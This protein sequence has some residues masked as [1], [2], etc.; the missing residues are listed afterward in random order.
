EPRVVAMLDWELATLGH[1]LADLAYNCMTYHLPAGHAVAAGF[2]GADVAALGLPSEDEYVA[3]YARRAGLAGIGDWQ[4]FMA[5][6]LFR[7]AAIQLGVYA[8][9]R[10]GNAASP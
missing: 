7:V 6:S 2:I 3:A 9:A 4:Y 1:P 10:L 5:F 8:R